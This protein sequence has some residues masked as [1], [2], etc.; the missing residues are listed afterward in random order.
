LASESPVSASAPD[1]PVT[2]SMLRIVSS[3]TPST[4]TRAFSAPFRVT[5]TDAVL[6]L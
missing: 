3:T 1:P 6:S 4:V 5:D 2:L